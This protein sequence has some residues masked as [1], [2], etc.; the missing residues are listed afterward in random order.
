MFGRCV[1]RVTRNGKDLARA[2][3]PVFSP[4]ELLAAVLAAARTACL[5]I[6]R[7]TP[8]MLVRPLWSR[9]VGS[10]GARAVRG[11]PCLLCS[12]EPDCDGS[13]PEL[14]LCLQ[15]L[16]RLS[17]RLTQKRELLA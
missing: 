10:V 11:V 3:L 9:R 17:G 16:L 12:Q 5:K 1:V 4:P 2:S 14:E 15:I 7:R 8:R 13:E 6:E